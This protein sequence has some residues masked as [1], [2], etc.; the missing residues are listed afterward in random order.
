MLLQSLVSDDTWR[1]EPG[2]LFMKNDSDVDPAYYK[3]ARKFLDFVLVS[4]TLVAVEELTN[5]DEVKSTLAAASAALRKAHASLV[6]FEVYLTDET[7]L[8]VLVLF[9]INEKTVKGFADVV[10]DTENDALKIVQLDRF[11]F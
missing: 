11:N 10:L 4:D 2:R 7:N 9:T 6:G 3:F 5:S 8:R 1:R